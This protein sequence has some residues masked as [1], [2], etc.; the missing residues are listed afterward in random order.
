MIFLE[1]NAII[2]ESKLTK[3]L[4]IIPFTF[5]NFRLR[6]NRIVYLQRFQVFNNVAIK[7]KW[8]N[9]FYLKTITM[10]INKNYD[11]Q[12]TEFLT[13]NCATDINRLVTVPM[14]TPQ[15]QCHFQ[16]IFN[17]LSSIEQTIILQLSKSENPILR[18]ELRQSLNLSS[19]DFNNGLQSLQQR[20]LVIKIKEEK[21]MF[22]LS[23]IFRE[24]VNSFFN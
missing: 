4:L 6:L 9:F 22:K 24:Y 3:Y 7:C 16:G 19:L 18:E 21:I 8:Y 23:S 1:Q 10:L 14:I 17:N 13:E 11:G 5:S 12:V 2:P 15:M 20:Y